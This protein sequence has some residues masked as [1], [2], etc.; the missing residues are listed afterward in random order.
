VSKHITNLPGSI[1]LDLIRSVNARK[2]F[3]TY[4]RKTIMLLDI[5]DLSC[6]MRIRWKWHSLKNSPL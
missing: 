6:T 3:K 2:R 1:P 5:L 4:C